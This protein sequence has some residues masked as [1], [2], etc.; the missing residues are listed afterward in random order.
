MSL[1]V[2]A[3][4]LRRAVRA[5][6]L[7]ADK[8]TAALYIFSQLQKMGATLSFGQLL[9]ERG[10]LSS[11]ALAALESGSEQGVKAVST[12]GDYELLEMVGEGQNGAVF[13]ARQISLDRIVALKILNAALAADEETL[14]HFEHEA[15]ATARLNHPNVVAGIDVGCDQG[16][17]YFA[18]ELVDGGTSRAL[19]ERSGGKLRETHA[20]EVVRQAAEGLKAAHAAGIL[21]RDLKPD[22]ILLT[23]EGQVKL[24][25][26]G[27]SQFT[28]TGQAHD[29]SRD[30]WASP[31]YVAPEVIEG[32]PDDKRSDVYSLGA[33]LFE[34]LAGRPP[35]VAD[36]A[37]ATMEMHLHAP[38]P[39]IQTYRHDVS[40]HTSALLKRMLA[41][42]LE[43]RVPSAA[44]VADTITRILALQTAPALSH[45]EPL[46][47]RT[48]T[49]P[50]IPTPPLPRAA[51]RPGAI[52]RQRSAH[53]S[54]PAQ[55]KFGGGV[56]QKPKGRR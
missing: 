23:K 11:M 52:K 41:K 37:Q 49:P 10:L 53:P 34:L 22:N 54:H 29:G 20:L 51:I 48:G 1:E 47:R 39:D 44:M 17:H 35:Y 40:I 24:A 55:K 30:F 2:E 13:R 42:T 33:T 27:I 36:S 18:M 6:V 5:K 25:D 56:R 28:V 46:P 32:L 9:V 16:L 21:H 45:A 14:A 8:G 15:R 26:L 50:S 3:Q 19:M 4:F 43:A 12:V 7:D 31:P 38:V